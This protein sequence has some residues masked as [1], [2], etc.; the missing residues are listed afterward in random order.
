MRLNH[1]IELKITKWRSSMHFLY[2][3]FLYAILLREA[4]SSIIVL[5]GEILIGIIT[6]RVIRG[7]E[8]TFLQVLWSFQQILQ[9]AQQ[10]TFSP[11]ALCI[12]IRG[13]LQ[14]H[15]RKLLLITIIMQQGRYLRFI[16]VSKATR[17]TEDAAS[18]FSPHL[19]NSQAG[20]VKLGIKPANKKLF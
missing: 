14:A 7:T 17:Q 5:L 11:L 18:Q 19:S 20:V 9:K 16:R 13:M 6:S 15:R 3:K 8:L 10:Q 12:E 2:L 4:K 1:S